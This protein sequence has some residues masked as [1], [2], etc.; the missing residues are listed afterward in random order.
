LIAVFE[1]R[2]NS[3]R[4]RIFQDVYAE[5]FD[6]ADLV[7]VREPETLVGLAEAERFSSAELVAALSERGRNSCYFSTTEE[8]IDFLLKNSLAGDVIAVLS[9]GGF[10]N[11]HSRLLAG[12]RGNQESV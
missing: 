9:N 3:S 7:V 5:C 11:I 2:T 1:P 6:S 12:L 8:I 4:R 10:D